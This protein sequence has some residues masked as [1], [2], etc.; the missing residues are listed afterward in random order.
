LHYREF[1]H[2]TGEWAT[3]RKS[4]GKFKAKTDAL[5]ASAPIMAQVNK[6]NNMEPQKLH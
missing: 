6:P 4:L 1:D 5:K 2:T 3:R